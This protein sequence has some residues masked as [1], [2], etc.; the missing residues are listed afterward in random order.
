MALY[1][2]RKD[3]IVPVALT[4]FTLEQVRE[5][6]DL[7][8]LLRHNIKAV[9]PE[10]ETMVLAEEFADWADSRRRIDLLAVD[11]NA[12][13]VVVELKRTE[14]GGHMDLQ[15][16]RYAAMVSTMTFDQA[17]AAHTGYLAAVGR[18][19]N[20]RTA[21]LEFLG[22]E[23]PNEEAFAQAVR[24]VLV[25]A[26]FSRELTTAVLWLNESGLD[27]RCVRMKPYNLDGRVLV[28]VQQIIP[29]PEAEDYVVRVSKK[30][31]EEK[32]AREAQRDY[33]KYDVTVNGVRHERLPKR[34]VMLALVRHLVA[35]GVSPEKIAE[36]SPDRRERV[37][38]SADGK[39][40]TA[41]FIARV[42]EQMKQQGRAF[43]PE[44][45]FCESD[46]LMYAEGRTYALTN[47]WG[48]NTQDAIDAL[49]GAFGG[50]GIKI[51]PSTD[52]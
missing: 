23:E 39:L 14:D 12:N 47:Q 11:K 49:L 6:G 38:R 41:T 48:I 44:R 15:A 28:D 20:A 40:D 27:M 22:W 51:Q 32:A 52:T 31:R 46:E 4:S 45:Y 34:K 29:L 36:A 18:Q 19:E 7:Q 26:E 35:R 50:E 42:R 17:V 30:E 33:T 37:L 10:P 8:R 21:I 25:S 1:E 43:D 9:C 24:I 2:L 16:I 3:E 13:L 5:R